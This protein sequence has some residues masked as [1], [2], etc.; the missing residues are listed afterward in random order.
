MKIGLT[1]VRG[2]ITRIYR[3]IRKIGFTDSPIYSWKCQFT[4]EPYS[5]E[6][7]EHRKRISVVI[8]RA[9]TRE[10]ASFAIEVV[11]SYSSGSFYFDERG[12]HA[13]THIRTH[14]SQRLQK[15]QGN[16][17]GDAVVGPQALH[18]VAEREYYGTGAITR[19]F[20]FALRLASFSFSRI[21]HYRR[22]GEG[23]ERGG[24]SLTPATRRSSQLPRSFQSRSCV[25]TD[26]RQIRRTEWTRRG[27]EGGRGGYNRG[28]M[29]PVEIRQT[30]SAGSLHS[31]HRPLSPLGESA[32]EGRAERSV[33]L[34]LSSFPVSLPFF[35]TMMHI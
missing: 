14:M 5:R 18:E 26:A 19:G 28:L 25:H 21:P 13:R 29:K 31:P 3:P 2:W 15:K 4:I 27:R 7:C 6:R 1:T 23:G 17:R 9:C 35:L 8:G 30:G 33:D 20:P 32:R 16:V 24:R 12:T 10:N 11:R 22:K 34:C